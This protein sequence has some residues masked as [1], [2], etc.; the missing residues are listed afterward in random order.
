MKQICKELEARKLNLAQFNALDMFARKGDWQTFV[1]ADKVKTLEVWEIDS[2]H[3]E[4]L[5]AGYSN[6]FDF[7]VIDYPQNSFGANNEFCE[8]FDVLPHLN[9]LINKK[10]IVVFNINKEPFNLPNQ[11]VWANKRAD[12]Y[13]LSNT[14]KLSLNFLEQ[15]YKKYFQNRNLNT[16]F[17]FSIFRVKCKPL[18]YLYYF[19]FMLEK[20]T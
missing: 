2:A 9:Q 5:K 18:D 14:V 11:V 19:V 20:N 15:F 8:H 6:A 13:K 10:A 17:N 7:I 12:F 3:E 16:L 4:D 1:Y